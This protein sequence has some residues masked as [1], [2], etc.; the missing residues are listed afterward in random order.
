M[1]TSTIQSNALLAIFSVLQSL[2]T[3]E[4]AITAYKVTISIHPPLSLIF[5]IVIALFSITVLASGT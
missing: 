1:Q 4:F 2:L 5:N 3:A